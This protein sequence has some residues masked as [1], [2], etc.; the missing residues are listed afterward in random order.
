MAFD[1][2]LSSPNR[3]TVVLVES[4]ALVSGE[5]KTVC[6]S[7]CG[8]AP[9]A[10]TVYPPAI[11]GG[12]SIS[13]KIDYEGGRMQSL[14]YGDILIANTDG[15]RDDWLLWVWSNRSVKVFLGD[16][17]WPRADFVCVFAGVVA[18]IDSPSRDRL[19]LKLRDGLQRLNTP[20]TELKLGGG[21]DNKDRLL[22]LSFGAVFNAEPLLVNASQHKYQ[23]HAGAVSS[24]VEVRDNGAPVK[25]TASLSAGTFTLLQQPFGTISA[26]VQQAT[27]NAADIIKTLVTQYGKDSER[28]ALDEI[29][30][31]S[32]D[33]VKAQCPQPVGVYLSDRRTVLDVCQSLAAS[34]GCALTVSRAGQLR[35][36]RIAA[37]RQAP[38]FEIGPS[39]IFD[40]S[41]S[42]ADRPAVKAA[43]KIGYA[44]NHLVQNSGLA[45]GI[46]AAHAALYAAESQTVT[47]TDADTQARYRLHGEPEQIDT[48]LVRQVDAQRE[49]ERL[50]SLFKVPRHIVKLT[51]RAA[52]LPVTLGQTV[53][54][55]HPRFGLSAGVRGVVVGSE[56]DWIQRRTTL[57]VLVW[58][59]P[60]VDYVAAPAGSGWAH[61]S[62]R[63]LQA[64]SPR[65]SAVT[66]PSNLQ[67]SPDTKIAGS[68]VTLQSVA[69]TVQTVVA[70]ASG[71]TKVANA[72]HAD[73]ADYATSAGS[74]SSASY[75]S[76]AGS[77]GYATSAGSASSANT[78]NYATSA[79]TA[80]KADSAT[81]ATTADSA[82]RAST[83]GT[84]DYAAKASYNANGEALMA[85][86]HTYY[87]SVTV[88]GV[89]YPCSFY[90][91]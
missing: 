24:L 85:T 68:T 21:S 64:A 18:D 61:E 55:T 33:A 45:G 60:P 23:I 38:D 91:N 17:T 78:A 48:D 12:V 74:A 59:V 73:R 30:T 40:G 20:V 35:L 31:A 1:D 76:S 65:L 52:F 66:L 10:H 84:A 34:V 4:S 3:K 80:S 28:F 22:P 32:F 79:G 62:V 15:S 19:A 14:G 44:K 26:D 25:F 16:A 72:T 75:A 51:A 53:L 39:D 29:D 43:V 63:T 86:G 87:G 2:W 41:L 36:I 69:A 88:N 82:T 6:I 42:I 8:Y 57:S 54:L 49:A 11:V 81:R 77:A 89:T 58:S 50:L 7:T 27:L 70:Y 47:Q 5:E 56:P 9:D 13:E 46:P 90:A 71:D 67:L 37:P 83:A